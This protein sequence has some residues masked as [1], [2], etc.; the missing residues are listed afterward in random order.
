MESK[1]LY[2]L[3]FTCEREVFEEAEKCPRAPAFALVIGVL[4]VRNCFAK[5]SSHSAQEDRCICGDVSNFNRR[6]LPSFKP[7][8]TS[9]RFAFSVL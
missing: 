6:Q 1:G 2:E 8:G 5:R 4:R 9:G 7:G 3:T